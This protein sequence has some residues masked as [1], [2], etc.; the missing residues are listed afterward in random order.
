MPYLLTMVLFLPWLPI[1]LSQLSNKLSFTE[2]QPASQAQYET[3]GTIAIGSAIEA[4]VGLVTVA[5]GLFLLFGL[6]PSTSR[7]RDWWSDYLPAAWALLSLAGYLAIGLADSFLRFL[8]PAQLAFALW[9]GRGVWLLWRSRIVHGHWLLRQIPKAAAALALVVCFIALFRG[10]EDLSHHPDFRRDDMRGLVRRMESD[11][12]P[13]DAVI[14]SALGLK[15]LLGYYY[16]AG[17]PVFGLPTVADDDITKAQVLEII[18]AH[19]RLHVIFYGADQQDPNLVIET[20]L[21]N[22]AFEISDRWVDDLRYA[23]YETMSTPGA[24]MQVE[25]AFGDSITLEAYALGA[26][27]VSAGDAL[28][29]QLLWSAKTALTQRYKVFL[30]LLDAQGRLAAQRD[31][32]PAGGSAMTT[33]W[34]VGDS[35]VDK[36]ALEIPSDLPAGEYTLIAGLYDIQDPMARLPVGQGTYF[37]LGTVTVQ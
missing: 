18:A 10:L 29:V 28:T 2:L 6:K 19:N 8:L 12:Q 24:L 13:G 20:T 23:R 21:N 30:Q 9:I 34:P 16:Q 14:V 15:E 11:L 36:H 32:E 26:D 33:A 4:N 3:L 27:V 37:E 5:V 25:Q 31:S 17:A 1:A 35:V 7:Q 22:Y